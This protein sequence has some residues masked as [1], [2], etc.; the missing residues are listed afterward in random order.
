MLP[1]A[2]IC[3]LDVLPTTVCYPIIQKNK[4]SEVKLHEKEDCSCVRRRQTKL[5]KIPAKPSSSVSVKKPVFAFILK[6]MC[7]FCSFVFSESQWRVKLIHRDIQHCFASKEKMSSG[8]SY[9]SNF[10][11]KSKLWYATLANFENQIT[12]N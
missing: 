2:P 7:C 10:E 12:K 6:M 1:H 9:I 8:W 4:S 11:I 3:S 5:G